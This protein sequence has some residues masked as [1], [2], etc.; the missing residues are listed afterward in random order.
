MGD[1][2]HGVEVVSID[3]EGGRAITSVS[4][5][6]IG[7]VGTAPDA[8][9]ETFPLNTPVLLTG[10]DLETIAKLGET[11]TLP[12]S[13]DGIF[14]QYSATVVVVRVRRPPSDI[15][16]TVLDS[17]T[18]SIVAVDEEEVIRATGTDVDSIV[19]SDIVGFNKVWSGETEYVKNEDWERDGLA[20]KWIENSTTETVNRSSETVDALTHQDNNLGIEKV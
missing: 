18:R 9:E 1:F 17:L 15:E 3:T 13:L 8:D 12:W 6:T 2:L 11:G 14:D 5:S 19:N 20:I 10:S 7:L 16:T 4:S